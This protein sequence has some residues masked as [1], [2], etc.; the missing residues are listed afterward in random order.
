M[1][2]STKKTPSN[3]RLLKC[4]YNYV[5]PPENSQECIGCEGNKKSKR[6]IVGLGFNTGDDESP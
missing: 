6:S 5:A 4:K 1:A 3:C 2:K